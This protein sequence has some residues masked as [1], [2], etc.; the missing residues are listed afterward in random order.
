MS[1]AAGVYFRSDCDHLC[2][3][4]CVMP[5]AT[6]SLCSKSLMEAGGLYPYGLQ[7]AG[8]LRGGFELRY[9]LEFLKCRRERVCQAP[10]CPRFEFRVSRLVSAGITE[11]HG[12]YYVAEPNEWGVTA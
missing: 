5:S 1:V 7:E 11:L 4:I 8:E 3:R 2:G 10:Q 6:A 9:G 12:R